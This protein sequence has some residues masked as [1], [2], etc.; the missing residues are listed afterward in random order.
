MRMRKD[1]D[2]A[3][4]EAEKRLALAGY[5]KIEGGKKMS[6]FGILANQFMIPFVLLLVIAAGLS[7]FFEEWLDGLQLL[8]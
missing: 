4:A 3:S 1:Q 6:I 5:N 8:Q 2:V 7:L